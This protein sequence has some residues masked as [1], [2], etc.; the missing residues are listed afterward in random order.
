VGQV[1]FDVLNALGCDL[2]ITEYDIGPNR[3]RVI[4]ELLPNEVLDHLRGKDAGIK[5]PPRAQDTLRS[6]RCWCAS[7]YARAHSGPTRTST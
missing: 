6:G 3:Y 4:R 7:G 2:E 5:A 1:A